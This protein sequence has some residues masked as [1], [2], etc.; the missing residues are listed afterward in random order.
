MGINHVG[1]AGFR[2]DTDD[3]AVRAGFQLHYRLAVEP[4]LRD[5]CC[6]GHWLVR[7][8]GLAY[9]IVLIGHNI[10]TFGRHDIDS[11]H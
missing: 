1:L 9:G 4:A 2:H 3:G 7:L 8:R 5:P 11:C 10:R 6:H